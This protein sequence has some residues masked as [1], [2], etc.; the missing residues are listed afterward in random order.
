MTVRAIRRR[1]H[2]RPGWFVVRIEGDNTISCVGRSIGTRVTYVPPS[3]FEDV[4]V[5][6]AAL[7]E[8]QAQEER[9]KIVRDNRKATVTVEPASRRV[10]DVAVRRAYKTRA[11]CRAKCHELDL[12]ATGTI[13]TMQARLISALFV[14]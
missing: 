4:R 5:F 11:R 8:R 2:I 14:G 12:D 13:E 6:G 10:V 1:T 7:A 3:W 9:R